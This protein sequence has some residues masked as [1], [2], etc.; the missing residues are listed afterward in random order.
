MSRIGKKPISVPDAV[1]ISLDPS[2]RSIKVEGPK[3]KLDYTYRPEVAVTWD[4]S[5][6]R[7]VCV[8]PE[9]QMSSGQM[10]AWAASSPPTGSPCALAR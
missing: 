7:I 9:D 8:I 2:K 1:K 3:G 4:E 6:K 5:E 10:R